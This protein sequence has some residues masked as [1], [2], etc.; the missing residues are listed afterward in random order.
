[1]TSFKTIQDLPNLPGIRR[2]ALSSNPKLFKDYLATNLSTS[3]L[4]QPSETGFA[5][6]SEYLSA[7]K[8]TLNPYP[9]STSSFNDTSG[10]YSL[11]SRQHDK[12]TNKK[13][14]PYSDLSKAPAFVT[15]KDQLCNFTAYFTEVVPEISMRP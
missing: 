3:S 15:N 6:E 9:A 2:S 4:A 14:L 11:C 8:T 1:M 13:T 5:D 7:L 12:A 10:R